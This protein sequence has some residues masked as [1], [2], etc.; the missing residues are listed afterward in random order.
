MEEYV[1]TLLQRCR[2][3]KPGPADSVFDAI[4]AA[5]GSVCPAQ[6][7]L[8]AVP[9]I[10][11]N[12]VA[13]IAGML[14]TA[15]YAIGAGDTRARREA[16]LAEAHADAVLNYLNLVPDTDFTAFLK[17]K[18]VEWYAAAQK[19][20]SRAPP[21]EEADEEALGEGQEGGPDPVASTPCMD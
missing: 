11:N 19:N 8:P 15:P 16:G 3:G 18:L 20:D 14:V 1:A 2:H 12:L 5:L 9:K 21:G 7:A 6:A 17:R 10:S 13:H 4:P